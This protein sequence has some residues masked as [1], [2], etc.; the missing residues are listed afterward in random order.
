MHAHHSDQLHGVSFSSWVADVEFDYLL[1]IQEKVSL[2]GTH[3]QTQIQQ[4]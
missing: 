3:T 1:Q 4:S 2:K